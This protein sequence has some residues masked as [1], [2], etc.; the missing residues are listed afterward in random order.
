MWAV[1]K[2]SDEKRVQLVQ[3]EVQKSSAFFAYQPITAFS[4]QAPVL[5]KQK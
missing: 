1:G 2:S 5:D 3:P 4:V